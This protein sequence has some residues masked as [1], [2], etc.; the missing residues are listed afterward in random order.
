MPA[1]NDIFKEVIAHFVLTLC[2]T[3]LPI[4]TTFTGTWK[5]TLIVLI[6]LEVHQKYGVPLY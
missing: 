2:A 5:T 1:W 4:S 3:L 6:V